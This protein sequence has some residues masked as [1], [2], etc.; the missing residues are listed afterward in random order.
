MIN[1]S[2]KFV[3]PQCGKQ[4][5]YWTETVLERKYKVNSK[6]GKINKIPCSQQTYGYG[7]FTDNEGF[8]CDNC[9]WTLN[10]ASLH[11]TSNYT[12]EQ[13]KELLKR[14]PKGEDNI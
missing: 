13:I 10:T 12:A 6:T 3:C 2:D 7:N 5:Y 11:S 14:Y 9:G 1:L 8:I 4:L